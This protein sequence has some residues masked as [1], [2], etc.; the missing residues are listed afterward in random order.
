MVREEAISQILEEA[1]KTEKI[2]LYDI[3]F[4][5]FNHHDEHLTECKVYADE[6]IDEKLAKYIDDKKTILEITNYGKFWILKGGYFEYLKQSEKKQK[7]KENN[8][9]ENDLDS[10]LTLARLKFTK[11]R[12]KTYWISFLLSMLSFIFSL[13]SLLIVTLKHDH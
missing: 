13:I 7:S 9:R 1:Y 11:Y 4:H 5:L 12:I 3:C 8:N 6:L 10:E 2:N